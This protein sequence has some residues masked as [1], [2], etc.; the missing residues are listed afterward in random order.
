MSWLDGEQTHFTLEQTMWTQYCFILTVFTSK[1]I[2][3]YKV[4]TSPECYKG[5]KRKSGDLYG[6]FFRKKWSDGLL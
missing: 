2:L 3:F 5:G 4:W 6:V 1:V